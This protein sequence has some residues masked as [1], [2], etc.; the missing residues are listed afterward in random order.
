M[1]GLIHNTVMN[2]WI[3]MDIHG[4]SYVD[5]GDV[6]GDTWYQWTYEQQ[7]LKAPAQVST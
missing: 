6:D 3:C 2:T 7:M 1:K 4:L 5:H